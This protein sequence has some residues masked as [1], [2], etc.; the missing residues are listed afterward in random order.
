MQY[1]VRKQTLEEK[2]SSTQGNKPTL[3]YA[4]CDFSRLY[5]NELSSST[6]ASEVVVSSAKCCFSQCL[7]LNVE[8]TE[9]MK[10]VSIIYDAILW[11]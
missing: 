10:I 11:Y 7:V 3:S 6:L 8:T 9:Q 5:M 2:F 4:V 1:S